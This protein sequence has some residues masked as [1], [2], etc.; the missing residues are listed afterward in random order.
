MWYVIA[1][2]GW[3]HVLLQLH[4]AAEAYLVAAEAYLVAAEA[5]LVAAEA[6]LVAYLMATYY[7]I[8]DTYRNAHDN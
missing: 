2:F 8:P 3:Q 4:F 1:R 7:F 6:Y 5:Y